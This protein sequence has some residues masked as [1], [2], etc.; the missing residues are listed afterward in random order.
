MPGSPVLLTQG[1][2][3]SS[4][5]ESM[6]RWHCWLP[7]DDEMMTMVTMTIDDDD[8]DGDGD[9]EEEETEEDVDDDDDGGSGNGDDAG[10]ALLF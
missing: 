5:D 6:R 2:P 9:D 3:V 8:D 1:L 7:R 4:A 10:D